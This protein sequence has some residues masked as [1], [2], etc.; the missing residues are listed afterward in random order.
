VVFMATNDGLI[1]KEG[2]RIKPIS[3]REGR[4]MN[5]VLD[6]ACENDITWIATNF[7]LIRISK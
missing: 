6:I 2:N 5:V 4:F 3:F 1:I 7:G